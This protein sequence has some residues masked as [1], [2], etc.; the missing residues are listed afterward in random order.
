MIKQLIE[1]SKIL[2]YQYPNFM[3]NFLV[4]VTKKEIAEFE[5][6]KKVNF[7]E[8]VIE[9][10]EWRNG[11]KN[12]YNEQANRLA[13]FVFGIFLSLE[14]GYEH[15]K[16]ACLKEGLWPQDYYPIFTSGVGDYFLIEQSISHPFI[17]FYSP[18]L[19]V[20]EPTSAFDS[21]QILIEA[22]TE[23]YSKNI[24]KRNESNELINSD[25]YFQF[26]KRKN[27]NSDYWK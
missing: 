22:I 1:L 5:N 13:L 21:L 8:E 16:N 18:A 27:P 15:Y 25:D 2:D 19:E 24:L 20:I 3:E 6:E 17:Y 26:M 4:G 7:P 11:I 14:D 23:A 10:Y 12:M 9:L